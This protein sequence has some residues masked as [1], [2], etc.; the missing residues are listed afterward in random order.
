MQVDNISYRETI[1]SIESFFRKYDI[2]FFAHDIPCNID[3]Q[4]CHDVPEELQGIKYINEYLRR[5]ILE[6]RFC[7]RFDSDIIIKLLE[8][9]CPDYRELLINIYEPVATN[10][11]GI[12]LRYDN[13]T[14]SAVTSLAVTEEDRR[15]LL[16]LFHQWDKRELV[17]NLRHAAAK[18]CNAL[19]V[20]NASDLK[21]LEAAAESL[22][23]RILA[24]LPTQRLDGIFMSLSRHESALHNIGE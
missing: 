20:S 7:S 10:A 13:A 5:F 8:A 9:C 21:Y 12:A 15:C 24:A 16:D 11:L 3:Y 22:C 4:L 17:K 6:N 23:P 19:H 18:V 14:Y 2:Q 1:L